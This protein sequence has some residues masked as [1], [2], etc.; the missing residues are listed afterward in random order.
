VTSW[1]RIS[2]GWALNLD[3]SD[4]AQ[5]FSLPRIEVRSSPRGWRSECLLPDGTRAECGVAS[6]GDVAEAKASAVAQA[7]RLLGPAYAAAL[8]LAVHL[9][10]T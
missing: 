3:G 6:Q 4:A 5:V 7:G 2:E 10:G 8:K 9:P 1:A